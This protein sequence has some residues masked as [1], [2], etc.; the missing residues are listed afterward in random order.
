[1]SF[2]NP[3]DFQ[4]MV[5]QLLNRSVPDFQ[6]NDDSGG[7][8]GCDGF[9]LAK[10][11]LYAIWCPE[12][13]EKYGEKM[14]S[15][16]REDLRKVP[17][18]RTRLGVHFQNWVFIA[19]REP[20][21]GVNKAMIDAAEAV[22]VEA[23]CEATTWLVN[24]LNACPEVISNFPQH[25]PS[26]AARGQLGLRCLR[27]DST[28]ASI[29]SGGWLRFIATYELSNTGPTV[30]KEVYWAASFLA[31][32]EGFRLDV[33]S[34]ASRRTTNIK[35][36]TTSEEYLAWPIRPGETRSVLW[37]DLTVVRLPD[38]DIACQMSWGGEGIPVQGGSLVLPRATLAQV[39]NEQRRIHAETCQVN[40][41]EPVK[42]HLVPCFQPVYDGKSPPF[43]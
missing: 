15:K 1:M 30:A 2:G 6:D 42:R 7:D 21:M 20:L 8:W 43:A 23:K 33:K 38:A 14:I 36:L 27:V 35:G 29:C 10:S 40:A 28:Y 31:D 4:R 9:S 16:I 32:G 34:P 19:P 37:V 22:A 3:E 24:L 11:T 18:L 5:K 26:L 25:F 39:R 41:P 13:F 12:K 17:Q